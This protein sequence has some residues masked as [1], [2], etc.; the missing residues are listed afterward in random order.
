M[1]GS[2]TLA[3]PANDAATTVLNLLE[4]SKKQIEAAIPRHMSADRLMR[5]ALTTMR[6]TPKLLECSSISLLKATLQCAALGLE[7]DPFLGLAYIIPFGTEATVIVGYKGIV[8]LA[9]NSGQIQSVEAHCVYEAD[10][11]EFHYGVKSNIVHVPAFEKDR[12]S[13]THAWAV[14]HF[15]DGGYQMEVMD[16]YELEA[17]RNQSKKPDTG[18]WRDHR[19]EMYKKTVIRRMGKLLPL[20]PVLQRQLATEEAIDLG[21]A[22]VAETSDVSVPEEAMA[23]LPGPG[24]SLAEKIAA[25]TGTAKKAKPEE[26]KGEMWDKNRE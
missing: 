19:P 20:S 2:T 1:A 25:N 15:K 23:S 9:R 10:K 12:G 24:D 4:R 17:I 11:F 8:H 13:I 6:T 5:V 22:T 18:P 26:P 14:A 21:Y 7:P 16:I 3:K